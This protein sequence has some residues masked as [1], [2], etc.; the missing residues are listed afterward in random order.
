MGDF[1]LYFY[2]VVLRYSSLID[3]CQG[4]VSQH[5]RRRRSGRRSRRWSG[6]WSWRWSVHWRWR[7]WRLWRRLK[8][9]QFRRLCGG[10]QPTLCSG[11]TS[12][13]QQVIRQLRRWCL[14]LQ[15]QQRR[16]VCGLVGARLSHSL[17]GGLCGGVPLLCLLL[18]GVQRRQSDSHPRGR[19]QP[20][21]RPQRHQRL[22]K[23]GLGV[24]MSLMTR[25]PSATAAA[26]LAKTTTKSQS[27]SSFSFPRTWPLGA[28]IWL[29]VRGINELGSFRTYKGTSVQHLPS[30]LL[31]SLHLFTFPFHSLIVSFCSYAFSSI[32][33]QNKVSWKKLLFR[34]S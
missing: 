5:W 34:F 14:L 26:A 1:L 30:P 17:Q 11:L 3:H 13:Q 29:S 20:K 15:R 25:R 6:R 27:L 33:T 24:M 2:T 18:V 7:R 4:R 8:V 21:L 31:P 23:E 28:V 16:A 9:L 12:Q 10:Q 22:P 32:F 19:Q